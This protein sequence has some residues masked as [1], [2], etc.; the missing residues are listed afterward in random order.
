M[1][2]TSYEM[3]WRLKDDGTRVAKRVAWADSELG[4]GAAVESACAVGSDDSNSGSEIAPLQ[5]LVQVAL[6]EEVRLRVPKDDAE[7][8]HTLREDPLEL[9]RGS[10]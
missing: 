6:G 3:G 7:Q 8:E 4:F 10:C 5:G 1:A 9:Y 2:G